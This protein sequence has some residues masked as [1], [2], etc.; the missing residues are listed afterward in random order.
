VVRWPGH[1]ADPA[2]LAAFL[3]LT[4]LPG[5]PHLPLLYPQVFAFRL[6]MVAVTHPAFPLPIWRALQVRNRLLQ[7]RSIPRDAA[8][9]LESAIA[10]HR[11]LAKGAEIDIRTSV[12]VGGELMWEGLTTFYYRGGFGPSQDA[13][14]QMEPPS[15]PPG[16]EAA[17]WELPMAA[18][19]PFARMTGDYNGIHRWNW[20]ARLMGFSRAFFHPQMIVGLCMARLGLPAQ[21]GPQSLDLWLKGPVY[22]GSHVRL[23]SARRDNSVEF[24]LQLEKDERPAIL[25]RWT[26]N[27]PVQLGGG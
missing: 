11:V 5:G 26:P 23:L 14:P 2:Q 21:D 3:K 7:H 17:N 8:M 22:T 18:S 27:G 4:G 24:G 6:Q 9:E 16:G 1:R 25:G 19:K 12:H 15:L 13:E 10:G 20:Y